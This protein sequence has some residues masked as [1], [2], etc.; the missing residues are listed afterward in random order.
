MNKVTNT[1]KEWFANA[2]EDLRV[3]QALWTLGPEKYLKTIPYHCQQT[4]EK[5]I[6]GYLAYKEI[7][8]PKIHDIAILVNL[9]GPTASELSQL[10]L[11]ADDLTDYAVAFR[12]PDASRKNEATVKDSE[13]ALELA[14]KVYIAMSALIPFDSQ[15]NL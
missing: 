10:L 5:S 12:Y 4:A 8:F 6:K 13:E 1:V 7:K 15:W 11:K 3:A 9:M 14:K 2:N